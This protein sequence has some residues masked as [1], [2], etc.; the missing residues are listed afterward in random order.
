MGMLVVLI[1]EMEVFVADFPVDMLNFSRVAGR[2]QA[3]CKRC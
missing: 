1:M 2:P 3:S